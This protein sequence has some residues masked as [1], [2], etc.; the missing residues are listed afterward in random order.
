MHQ[1][2]HELRS[3]TDLKNSIFF[4]ISTEKHKLRITGNLWFL[5][6]SSPVTN[7][8]NLVNV[9]FKHQ[10][11]WNDDSCE[12]KRQIVGFAPQNKL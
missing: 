3:L 9:G 10:M 11:F 4:F 1:F 6:G 2:E 12:K 5:C 8:A 7:M